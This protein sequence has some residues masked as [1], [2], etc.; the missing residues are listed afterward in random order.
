MSNDD[1]VT[2][3]FTIRELSHEFTVVV[4]YR[5]GHV[6]T[7][8]E[9]NALNATFTENIR[10]NFTAQISSMKKEEGAMLPS[11]EEL[12]AKLDEYVSTYSFG[13]RR[14]RGQSAS[15]ANPVERMALSIAKGII[16]NAIVKKGQSVR[17]VGGE[18]IAQLAEK[19]LAGTQGAGIRNE[20]SRRLAESAALGVDTLESLGIA[21]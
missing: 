7:E 12:Q 14:S 16:K 18:K 11:V 1:I 13:L 9:A 2:K 19:L 10:N 5:E 3:S 8:V 17:A 15:D 4:P 6:L 20:A 21:A